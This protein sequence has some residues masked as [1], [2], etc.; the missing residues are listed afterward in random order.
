MASA[1]CLGRISI[2]LSARPLPLS[3]PAWAPALLLRPPRPRWRPTTT[4]AVQRQQR[5][6]TG[7]AAA[8]AADKT[9][10]ERPFIED[11]PAGPHLQTT[12]FPGAKSQ[13]AIAELD[14]VFD[15]SA[16]ASIPLGYNNAALLAAASS[17]E[18]AGA[19][20]NRPALGNFPPHDWA[21]ILQT[22]VLAAAPPGLNQV[23]TALAGSDANES[24]YKAAFMWRR[25]RERGSRHAA[26]SADE[27]RSAMDNAAPG[28]PPL[29]ILSFRSAFHGRL[30]ASLSTTRS[31]PI[32]KLDIPAFPWPQAPFPR[33]QYPLSAH[34]AA[35]AAEEQRCLDETARLLRE[36]PQ[37]V[38]AVVVEPIQSEGGDHHASPAFFRALRLLTQQHGVL[39]IVDEVQTGVGAT[40]KFWAHEHWRLPAPPDIVT[41]SK[42]AQMA[43]FFYADR[44]LRPNLPYRLFNTWM[45][46]PPRALLFRAVVR[47]IQRLGLVEHTARVGDYLFAELRRLADR[48]PAELMNLRGRGQGTFIAW[49]S[50]RR[51]E[52]LDRVRRVAGVLMGGSGERAVRL[53]PMLVFQRRHD[54]MSSLGLACAAAAAA[55]DDDDADEGL[56]LADI[57]LDAIEKTIKA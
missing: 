34:A 46:D 40:G 28:S 41:F 23:F 51:E 54:P 33:L 52:F 44:H 20:A 17:R 57:L 47:E 11:E 18:M 6:S 42:K 14:A 53:R 15:T 16:I 50:P 12:A 37:P 31:K 56:F 8:T 3:R 5:P 43:G 27:Q 49:D 45:G 26:F 48:Y 29:S 9:G 7:A 22:G 32:H 35:N 13:Q 19:I 25:Q 4:T 10:S 2:P 38:A 36:W 30:F 21:S 55:A 24:A 39:L 1:A